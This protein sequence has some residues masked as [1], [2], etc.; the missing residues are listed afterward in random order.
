[1][2]ANSSGGGEK[3]TKAR[4][5]AARVKDPPVRKKANSTKGGIRG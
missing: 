3:K 5:N 2:R 1:M 4:K